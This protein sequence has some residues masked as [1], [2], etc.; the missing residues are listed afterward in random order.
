MCTEGEIMAVLELER[1][2][3]LI[4]YED[5]MREVAEGIEDPC[6]IVDGVRQPMTAP[7]HPHQRFSRRLTVLIESYMER[8]GG[9]GDAA[10]TDLMIRENPLTVREPDLFYA[11]EATL[12]KYGELPETGSI[13]F[14]VDLVIEILSPSERRKDIEGKLRDYAFIGVRECWVVS[15]EA[16]NVTVLTLHD[17]SYRK[18]NVFITGERLASATLPGLEFDIDWLFAPRKGF[19]VIIETDEQ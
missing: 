7:N 14:P 6:E 1:E 10:P 17:G 18:A 5:Y 11:T 9:E 4:T 12:Q 3:K 8:F 15:P 2:Q 19:G 16:Q 13:K